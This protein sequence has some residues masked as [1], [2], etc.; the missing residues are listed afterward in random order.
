[1]TLRIAVVGAVGTTE[2]AI[3]A[4]A[5]CGHPP[6]A[7]VTIPL[8]LR[9]RHSDFVDLEPLARQCGATV[10]RAADTADPAVPEALGALDLD[11]VLV[12]GWSRVCGPEIRR[13]PRIGALGYHPTFLPK[14]RGRA[15]LAWTIIL[16][17]RE[18]AGTLFWLDEGV[19]SGD[20]AAQRAFTVA[21][22]MTLQALLDRHL[23]ALEEM[24]PPL[25]RSLAKGERPAVPQDHEQA[26]YLAV[27]RPSHGE[28]DWTRPAAE[29]ER[30]I[31]AVS[32]PYPGAFTFLRGQKVM[33]WSAKVVRYPQWHAQTGQ[34][35]AHERSAPIVRCGEGTDLALIEYEMVPAAEP[36]DVAAISGQPLLGRTQ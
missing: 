11:I 28:I 23:V 21:P 12:V 22:D 33:V 7:I 35:F 20:I 34:V 4:L 8:E 31:R 36:G 9:D 15:A 6:V 1:M 13:I 29:I 27:R 32:R 10:I 26:T 18:T 17:V 2:V 24:I 16:D 5:G 14:M 3:R 19:D 25:F 30:L